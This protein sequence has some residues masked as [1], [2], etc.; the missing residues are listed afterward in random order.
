MVTLKEKPLI[1]P[2]VSVIIPCY[3][4]GAYIDQAVQSV[5]DQTFE[6]FEIII[7]DDGSTDPATRRLLDN[8]RRPKTRILRT[9]NRGLAKTRNLGIREARAPY[10]TCLDADDMFEKN[11]LE[12]TV[13]V[14]DADPSIAF[15]SCWLTAFDEADFLWNPDS[16]EFPHLL[17]EH[18]VCTAALTRSDAIEKVGGYDFNMPVAGYEDWDIA[19]SMVEQGLKGFIIPEPLFRYRIRWRSGSMSTSCNAPENHIRLLEYLIDKHKQSY[20]QHFQGVLEIIEKRTLALKDYKPGRLTDRNDDQARTISFLQDVLNGVL[21]SRNWTATSFLRKGFAFV[22]RTRRALQSDRQAPRLSVLVYCRDQGEGLVKTLDSFRFQHNATDEIIIMDDASSDPITLQVLDWCSESGY[23]ILRTDRIGSV[24]ARNIGLKAAR[25]MFL[26]AMD[27][28]ETIEPDFF[29]K[30]FDLLNEKPEISFLTYGLRDPWT[31]FI[32]KPDTTDLKNVLSCPRQGFPIVHRDILS[33]AGGYD[34]NMVDVEQANWDLLIRLAFTGKPGLLLADPPV[35]LH[36]NRFLSKDDS[37]VP[38]ATHSLI[39]PVMEKHRDLFFNHWSNIIVRHDDLRSRLQAHIEQS[40]LPDKPVE[41]DNSMK[42]GFKETVEYAEHHKFKVSDQPRDH[43]SVS[44]K[45][46]RVMAMVSAFNEGDIISRI[47]GHLVDNGIEVYLIDNRSTDDTVAQAEPWLG[48]GLVHI[49]TFPPESESSD[50][51]EWGAILRRK[52]ELAMELEADWF[53][54][55]DADE[56]RE[57]P[58]PGLNLKEAIRWVDRLGY[59]CIDF[60]VFNFPPIDD[61]FRPGDDPETYFLFYEDAAEYDVLQ[62]KCWKAVD[63]RITLAHSGGHEAVFEDR[64]VFPV[65]FILRH[66][67]IRSQTHGIKK[68]FSERR[69]RLVETERKWGWHQQYNHIINESHNFL[70]N[71]DELRMFDID[72]IQMELMSQGQKRPPEEH[73][74]ERLLSKE[75]KTGE[76]LHTNYTL[77]R[78][79]DSYLVP[80]IE[81]RKAEITLLEQKEH[82]ENL[83]R[84]AF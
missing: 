36:V 47:I 48:R 75:K 44:E 2:R 34:E 9:L 5:L 51:F 28:Y 15:A 62:L 63:E 67:P 7:I 16:C 76:L 21:R 70:K 46:F 58:F 12:R 83:E 53:I 66:Y 27:A 25:G 73:L 52:E 68:V 26:F 61:N 35:N 14:L 77:E 29:W 69:N 32:W 45:P 22:K 82:A 4:L 80:L 78:H 54:H 71:P 57:S 30:A 13:E 49:E 74:L 41:N 38:D 6:D 23:I 24:K 1:E 79:I 72:L 56:I 39:K 31:G 20:K 55:H 84:K 11:F 42:F 10:V 19:I 60:R 17:A 18:T 40:M 37:D 65:K 50:L 8:Y 64:V 33:E 81:K 3:N 59:N 43:E